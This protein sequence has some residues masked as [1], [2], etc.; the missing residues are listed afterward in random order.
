MVSDA[1]FQRT[2]TEQ[3][4][5]STVT[6]S[7]RRFGAGRRALTAWTSSVTS[8]RVSPSATT[9]W[10]TSAWSV[11][12]GSLRQLG[13]HRGGQLAPLDADLHVGGEVQERQRRTTE[14]WAMCSSAARSRVE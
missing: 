14:V 7:G 1:F 8:V 4:P 12:S 3:S 2:V 10:A 5:R 11:A 6:G 9:A 13:R